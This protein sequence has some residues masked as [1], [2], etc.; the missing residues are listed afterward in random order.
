MP[1]QRALSSLFIFSITISKLILI[2]YFF[3]DCFSISTLHLLAQTEIA[4]DLKPLNQHLDCTSASCLISNFM[5]EYT[6]MKNRSGIDPQAIVKNYSAFG[7]Q[8]IHDIGKLYFS[9]DLYH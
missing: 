4:R 7:L 6:D 9:L 2:S 3:Q 8:A 1:A 5:T